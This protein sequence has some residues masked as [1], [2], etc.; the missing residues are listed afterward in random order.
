MLPYEFT[1]PDQWN[2]ASVVLT[3]TAFAMSTAGGAAEITATLLGAEA[4]G[5]LGA[6]VGAIS[7]NLFHQVV[8]N[9]IESIFSTA[10]TLTTI[11]A[12]YLAG[13]TTFDVQDGTLS[14]TLGEASATAI[15]LQTVGNAVSIGVVDAAVDGYS[16]A[17]SHGHVPGAYSWFGLNLGGQTFHIG[18]VSIIF[19]K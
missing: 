15:A 13:K 9:P 18:P 11:G 7:G 3:D 12:D 8:T 1:S 19:G 2:D 16:S 5:P 6:T 14:I 17:Y 10:A 4:A